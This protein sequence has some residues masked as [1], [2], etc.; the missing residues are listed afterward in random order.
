MGT[1]QCQI[2]N[3]EGVSQS[4]SQRIITKVSSVLASHAPDVI[5]FSTDPDIF[6]SVS[7]GSYGFKGSE[8]IVAD[9]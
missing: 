2:G 4:S 8:L 7:E 1:F 6:A 5:Q 3:S 9:M